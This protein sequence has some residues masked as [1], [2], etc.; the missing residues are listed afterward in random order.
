MMIVATVHNS[1]ISKVRMIDKNT[2]E[3]LRSSGIHLDLSWSYKPNLNPRLSISVT[4][5]GL[6]PDLP[7][8]IVIEPEE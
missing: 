1:R 3:I 6:A 5:D 2:G 8:T 7:L 4:A